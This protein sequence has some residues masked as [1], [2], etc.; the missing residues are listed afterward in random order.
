MINLKIYCLYYI[1]N[2]IA[3]LQVMAGTKFKA[4]CKI[5]DYVDSVDP[6]LG[7]LIRGTCTDLPLMAS[8]YKPGITFLMPV[9]K[10]FRKKLADLAYSSNVD[11][12]TK[13]ADMLNVLIIRD[14]FKST[15]D[16][17]AHKDDIPNSL[18]PP[19]HVEIDSITSSEVVFKSGA[20]ATIDKG[21]IDASKRSQ[22]A[23]WKLTGEIPITT[24]NNAKLKYISNK[25]NKTGSYDAV[26]EGMYDKERFK[27][28]LAIEN[29][30]M[31]S[32]LQKS[33][34]NEPARDVYLEHVM[35]MVDYFNSNGH[36][37]LLLSR[38]LPLICCDKLDLYLLIEPHK[39]HGP[40]LIDD[41][42]IHEWWLQKKPIDIQK[43]RE[44]ID[45]LL[46]NSGRS[47][48]IYTDRAALCNK[49]HEIRSKIN[50]QLQAKPRECIQHI[51]SHYN[52]F[53]SSNAIG[54]LGPVYPQ[55]IA[56]YYSRDQGLKLM[57]DEL[58]FLMY[59][60]FCEL[61]KSHTFDS[62]KYHELTNIIGE[63][64]FAQSADDRA[65]Q[66]KLLNKNNLQHLISPGNQILEIRA[67][68]NSTAFMCLPLTTEEAKSLPYKNSTT[69]PGANSLVIYNIN[70]T[71]YTQHPRILSYS[72][73][74]DHTILLDALNG[75]NVNS[76]D[77]VLRDKLRAKFA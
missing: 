46:S 69:R 35:S 41:M 43:T 20:R 24:N 62:G 33:I 29:L 45:N 38:V 31:L 44:L 23:V 63:C 54:G 59:D 2:N 58:R 15:S 71:Q 32:Q 30:Y 5:I 74:G 60:A 4:F 49:V 61:E 16:W 56:D 72:Q 75:L 42:V 22:L 11:D 21:F 25:P 26:A 36:N 73:G 14:V 51:V 18:Y 37:E 3:I 50:E 8:R 70:K 13:A 66:H 17:A 55:E 57:H 10:T 12:V 68:V 27:I 47:E 77:P 67:F 39:Q 65:R 53:T 28:M 64:L 19:Q 40:Y 52:E 9:D 34:N 6:E 7:Q 48:L 76:L 1:T